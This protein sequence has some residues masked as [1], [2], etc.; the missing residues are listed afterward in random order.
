MWNQEFQTKRQMLQM[1]NNQRRIRKEKRRRWLWLCWI[2][3]WKQ[4]VLL[5]DSI[6]SN[7]IKRNLNI[8]FLKIS[9]VIERIGC[10]DQRGNYQKCVELVE[11]LRVENKE[12]SSC[13]RRINQ[14]VHGFRV[15]WNE[16]NSGK[17]I[18]RLNTIS[19]LWK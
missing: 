7:E 3:A 5:F 13:Q 18:L 4:Y 9:F 12:L 14:R 1:W 19:L 15:C 8:F 6:F 11:Q 17:S 10:V 16:F 2:I